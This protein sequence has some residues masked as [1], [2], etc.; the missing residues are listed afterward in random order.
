MKALAQAALEPHAHEQHNVAKATER[1][2]EDLR[3]NETPD[4]VIARLEREKAVLLEALNVIAYEP[5]GGPEA[6]HQQVLD[7]IT[8]IARAAITQVNGGAK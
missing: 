8:N 6:T 7:Q 5:I 3:Y 2:A 1:L 4:D